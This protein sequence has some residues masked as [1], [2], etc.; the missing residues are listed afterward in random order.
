MDPKLKSIQRYTS[1]YKL[2]SFN[3]APEK[4]SEFKSSFMLFDTK[5]N[6]VEEIK[7]T[8][9]A[10]VEERIINQYDAQNKL[11]EES[12]HFVLDN[13]FEKRTIKR[14]EKGFATE[15]KKEYPDG[16]LDLTI[17]TLDSNDDIVEVLK[18]N[19]DNT[20]EG[21]VILSYE[22]HK[23]I[24]EKKFDEMGQVLEHRKQAYDSKGNIKEIIEFSPEENIAY[25]TIYDYDKDGYN[26][27]SSYFDAHENLI[28]KTTSIHDEKGN[29]IEKYIEDFSSS[30][31]RRTMTFGYDDKNNCI[32]EAV[33][34]ANGSLLRKLSTKFDSFGN[35]IEELNF[36]VDLT[37]GG[38]DEYYGNRYEYEFYE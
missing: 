19:E 25:K 27:A 28:V 11:I 21:K 9:G 29:L 4:D 2:L 32:E 10:E 31:G 15:E 38:R 36:E 34:A 5:G 8:P 6:I 18:Y 30:S 14:N 37:H 33:F 23:V 13:V 20:L 16:S 7:Y 22:N 1:H 26:S 3:E 12:I 24:E 35:P 17:Y